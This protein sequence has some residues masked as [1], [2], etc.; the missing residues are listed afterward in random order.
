M[1][2]PLMKAPVHEGDFEK[3]L[4]SEWIVDAKCYAVIDLGTTEFEYQGEKKM[5]RKIQI[6]FETQQM[7]TFGEKGELPLTVHLTK[8]FSLHEKSG[9]FPLIKDWALEQAKE[10]MFNLVGMPAQLMISHSTS[11]NDKVYAE[12]LKI[13][14]SKNDFE[15]V[16][17]EVYFSLDS[18]DK[19]E[20]DKLP[21]FLKKKVM[22]T[23]EYKKA[24]E[25]ID[26]SLPF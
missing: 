13:K 20:F 19:D 7:W 1:T 21:D 2:K 25:D 18:F 10:N 16:N 4:V 17:P 11:K 15:L 3:Q 9:L 8:T 5:V 12:I 22:E 26:N 24:Q 23:P 14:P 6:S